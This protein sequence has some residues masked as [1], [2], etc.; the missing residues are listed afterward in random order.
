MYEHLKKP[1]FDALQ[2][3]YLRERPHDVPGQEKL[4]W[5]IPLVIVT[6]CS[7]NFSNTPA[8]VWM[9]KEREIKILD[10]P[11]DDKFII[12]NPEEIGT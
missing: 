7:L 11:M 4:I 5:W 6:E 10:M 3:V 2:R 12:V 9:K 1:S 8:T